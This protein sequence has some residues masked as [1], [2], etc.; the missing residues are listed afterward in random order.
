[1]CVYFVCNTNDIQIFAAAVLT[2]IS[3]WTAIL[4]AGILFAF[5]SETT[6]LVIRS[7]VS[8]MFVLNIDEIV[9]AACCPT[10]V[11]SNMEE[12][13]YKIASL[14][15]LAIR[16]CG[17]SEDTWNSLTRYYGLYGHLSLMTI[18][19]TALVMWLRDSVLS[20]ETHP[21]W[22]TPEVPV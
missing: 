6:D 21:M 19:S 11:A 7:A 12:T 16:S 3:S 13:E 17:I 5:T 22:Q 1:V 4:V 14:Q 20:C 8:V 15:N 10:A 9:F 2:E 18:F